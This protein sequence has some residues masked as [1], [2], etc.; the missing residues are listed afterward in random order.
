[1]DLLLVQKK[2]ILFFEPNKVYV[3]LSGNILMKNHE[4]SV[5]LPAT[6]AKFGE[7][8]VLNF[9]QDQSLMFNSVETFFF[10][11]VETEIAVFEKEYF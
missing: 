1:M 4:V 7:S 6:C 2:D 9:M 5:Q 10:A 11:Q 8:N 3:I